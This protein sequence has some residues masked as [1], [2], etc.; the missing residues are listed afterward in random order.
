MDSIMALLH[1]MVII[2]PRPK[3]QTTQR[4]LCVTA[5]E[6]SVLSEINHQYEGLLRRE[7]TH[8][9]PKSRLS[10][11]C[12][13]VAKRGAGCFIHRIWTAS[14]YW[15]KVCQ[16]RQF[17]VQSRPVL[18][19]QFTQLRY[20]QSCRARTREYKH[21]LQHSPDEFELF[22]CIFLKYLTL[23]AKWISPFQKQPHHRDG[24]S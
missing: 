8:K 16:Y 23:S 13:K 24:F 2:M 19:G 6:A 18:Y 9:C 15:E 12:L 3:W 17:S 7:Y 11:L 4:S 22:L 10:S 14:N 20:E 21:V 5:P 1:G